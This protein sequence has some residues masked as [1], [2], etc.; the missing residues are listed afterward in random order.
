[1]RYLSKSLVSFILLLAVYLTAGPSA[2]LAQ[3][4]I[5]TPSG[6]PTVQAGAIGAGDTTQAGRTVRDGKPS[7]CKGKTNGL[8]NTTAVRRDF[9]NFVSPVTGCATVDMDMTG[10]GGGT[11]N[12]TEVVAYSPY[13][14]ASPGTGIIGDPGFSTIGTGSFS[15]PVTLG[16]AFTLVVHEITPLGG[17]AAYTFSLQYSTGCRYAG[18]DRTNDGKADPTIFRPTTGDWF[19]LNSAGGFTTE[20]FGTVGDTA[21]AGD[22]TGDG[23]TDSAVFRPSNSVWY[24]GN[25]H[26]NPGTNF[27]ARK[28]GTTGDIPVPGDFDRDGKNDLVIWRP[29][30]GTWHIFFSS[31]NTADAI[32]W[33][34]NGDKPVVGDYDGDLIADFAIARPE[35]GQYHWFILESNFGFG[36]LLAPTFGLITDKIVP[37]DYDGDG[38]TD[39]AVWRP[40][41]GVWYVFSSNSLSDLAFGP[42]GLPTDIPQPADYDGDKITDLAVFRSDANPANNFW[43]ILNSSNSS[44]TSVE[45]G[46]LGDVPVTAPVAAP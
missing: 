25:S 41:N 11:P 29:G 8:Q 20:N 23:V 4:Q 14:A 10:C 2:I 44:V 45:W 35:A 16:Q 21:V 46:Q 9:Y 40:S 39:V 15:F 19:T 13:N 24:Y 30:T 42:F 17:C 37:G 18:Y 36:F 34:Q 7:S 43:H 12:S 33:G 1:M 5:C 31:D 3:Q 32:Q 27:T 38:K 6:A 22:Y 26:T 28:F